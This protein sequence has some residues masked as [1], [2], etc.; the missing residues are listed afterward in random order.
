VTKSDMPSVAPR[1]AAFPRGAIALGAAVAAVIV[2]AFA[3][4]GLV[5]P[6]AVAAAAAETRMLV[7]AHPA[8]STFV[9]SLCYVALTGLG[10]PAVSWMN[11]AAGALFGPWVGLPV[12]VASSVTGAT[13]TMLAA[14][15]ALRGWVEARFPAAV[16][17][18]EK[19]AASGGARFLFAAR[20]APFL[21]FPLVNMAAG[22]TRMPAR[23]F[24]LVSLV[25][26]LPL[27]TAYVLAG[28]QLA[29]IRSPADVLSPQFVALLV[30]LA[31][32]PFAAQFLLKGRNWGR[33]KRAEA[34]PM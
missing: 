12:A 4:R 3:F 1:V 10:V 26:L 25:G 30:A 33:G 29:A 18:F 31:A 8:L 5:D 15:Y 2:A 32:A 23:I 14:R 9:F 7:S 28:A 6:A 19:G 17:R 13:I 21:P 20:L 24:V 27:S 16:A 22:V 34:G 11:V